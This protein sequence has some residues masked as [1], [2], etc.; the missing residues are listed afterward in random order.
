ML[1]L[2]DDGLAIFSKILEKGTFK[3]PPHN[4]KL[5]RLVLTGYEPFFPQR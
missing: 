5:S 1:A 2:E 4:T 3:I